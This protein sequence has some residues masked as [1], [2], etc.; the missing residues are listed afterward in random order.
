[1][2]P[3]G[4]ARGIH[5]CLA[6]RVYDGFH[7]PFIDEASEDPQCLSSCAVIPHAQLLAS[8]AVMDYGGEGDFHMDEWVPDLIP[9]LTPNMS[10]SSAA[11]G[12]GSNT[13]IGLSNILDVIAPADFDDAVTSTPEPE[14]PILWV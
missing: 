2:E 8:S 10:G 7:T 3:N 12:S 9:D 5:T 6:L 13:S 1:M 14:L 4:L 11:S